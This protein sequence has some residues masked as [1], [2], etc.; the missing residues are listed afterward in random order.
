MRLSALALA[1][2]VGLTAFPVE[3]RTADPLHVYGPG[4][5]AP[6]LREAAGAYEARTGRAV[7]VVAGPTP[8]WLDRAKADGDVIFSGSETMMTDFVAALEGRI[9]A[10]AV[11]PLYLRVSSVLVRPGNPGDID[12][13]EDL[14]QPGHRILVVNGAGQNGLWED[15]AGRTGD[16]GKVRA[17]RRNIVVYARNSA[18]ARQ[19]WIDD[20][21]LDA[22][23]IWGIWQTANPDLAETVEVEEPYRIY[24][25]AGAVVTTIGREDPD[26]QRF[27][28]FLKSEDGAAI[29]ARWGWRT[30]QP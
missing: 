20:P 6:A 12:G 2:L 27:L 11:E 9:T 30:G 23:I 29:F 8:Q 17:L 21:T 19:A 1:A 22:W 25:D 24:R 4:G 7:E 10:E 3:S 16:I 26:A 14:F 28:D 5:P 13:L 15:M 18:E